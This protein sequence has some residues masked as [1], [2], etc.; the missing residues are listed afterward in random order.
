MYNVRADARVVGAGSHA[1]L[2]DQ[3]PARE[4]YG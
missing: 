4:N 1:A 3:D 2:R